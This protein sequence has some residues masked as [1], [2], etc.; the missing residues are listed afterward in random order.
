MKNTGCLIQFPEE[1]FVPPFV[2]LYS[3]QWVVDRTDLEIKIRKWCIERIGPEDIPFWRFRKEYVNVVDPVNINLTAVQ[4]P[5]GIYIY[6]EEDMIAFKLTFGL[7]DFN[8]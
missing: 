1:N 4:V 2:R 7:N 3:N 6:D 5:T 8:T